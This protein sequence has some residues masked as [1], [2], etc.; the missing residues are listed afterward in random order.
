MDVTNE[1]RV[2]HRIA[3]VDALSPGEMAAASIGDAMVAV[4]NVD[5]AFYCTSNVCTH[6]FALLSDGWLEDDVVECPLHGGQFNVRSGQALGSPV[7]CDLQTY[8][9]RIVDGHVEACIPVTG[10][11]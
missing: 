10:D 7:E 4:Y 1:S 11:G 3:S 8:P 9:V 2:W 5:G 6:A